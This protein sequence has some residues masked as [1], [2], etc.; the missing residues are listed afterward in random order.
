M[1]TALLAVLLVVVLPVIQVAV[2][3]R[4]GLPG[5][6]P[7]LVL[8]GLVALAPLLRPTAGA[9]LGFAA[10]L[11][12]DVI[13]P[14]DHS[15]GRLALVLCLAGWWCARVPADATAGSRAGAA[16]LGALGATLLDGVLAG[17]LA[18]DSWASVLGRMPGALAWTVPLAAVAASLVPRRRRPF[19]RVPPGAARS[20]YARGRHA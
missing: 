9:V 14:A 19:G 6:G 20:P 17:V 18:D 10:G 8:A 12:A 16:A 3:N 11:A 4:M 1:R 15:I 13:P 2:V 5:G 7:D